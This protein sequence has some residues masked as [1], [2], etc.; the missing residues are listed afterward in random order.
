[1]PLPK[2]R[3]EDQE[4]DH[5]TEMEIGPFHLWVGFA[6]GSG[7]LLGFETDD[8]GRVFRDPGPERTILLDLLAMCPDARLARKIPDDAFKSLWER[9]SDPYLYPKRRGKI[10][11]DW[12]G[13]SPDIPLPILAD[14]LQENGCEKAATILRNVSDVD[15]M[16]ALLR[17]YEESIINVSLVSENPALFQGQAP[18]AN[19]YYKE[20]HKNLLTALGIE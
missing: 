14:W 7:Y 2:F 5:V 8:E 18:H 19:E 4:L 20:A 1:M 9:V 12:P 17:R 13:L 16:E 3:A 10:R 11:K 6:Y 15:R